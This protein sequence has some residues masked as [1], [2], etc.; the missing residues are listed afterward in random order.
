[1]L[2]PSSKVDHAPPTGGSPLPTALK[3][4]LPAIRSQ[5]CTRLVKHI[6]RL[7]VLHPDIGIQF[8]KVQLSALDVATLQLL[9]DDI[10]EQL[11]ID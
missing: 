1:M 11:G 9:L 3:R 2:P 10:N 8:R 7:R 5:S 4:D 6:M